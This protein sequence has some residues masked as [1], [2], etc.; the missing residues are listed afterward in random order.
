MQLIAFRVA[1]NGRRWLQQ[2]NRQQTQQNRQRQQQATDPSHQQQK[3]K[4]Q[5]QQQQQ[6]RASVSSMQAAD[7]TQP[8]KQVCAFCLFGVL[9]WTLIR[10]K[11]LGC[12]CIKRRHRPSIN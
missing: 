4:R 2:Q 7:S 9:F 12:A 11:G 6:Q 1:Q 10:R 3:A 5:K 8:N